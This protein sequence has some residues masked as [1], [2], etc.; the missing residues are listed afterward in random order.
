VEQRC[1]GGGG[2]GWQEEDGALDTRAQL[3]A[4]TAVVNDGVVAVQGEPAPVAQA[5]GVVLGRVGVHEFET[6]VTRTP[7]QGA[8]MTH[9]PTPLRASW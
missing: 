6:V 5:A 9:I 2:G 7:P 3:A 8:E 1:E 4:V